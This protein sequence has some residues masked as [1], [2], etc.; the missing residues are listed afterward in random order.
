MKFSCHF[1]KGS[2]FH[3]LSF[4][5]CSISW[6]GS[7]KQSPLEVKVQT[8]L[9]PIRVRELRALSQRVADWTCTK[10]AGSLKWSYGHC[11]IMKA[12]DSPLGHCRKK[13]VQ[14]WWNCWLIPVLNPWMGELKLQIVIS[15]RPVACKTRQQIGDI[16]RIIPSGHRRRSTP[17]EL[18]ALRN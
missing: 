7:S 18:S 15:K 11:W 13:P 6:F 8:Q 2:N 4:G 5:S 14:C 10:L 12:T 17:E 16:I 9:G 3:L 1:C